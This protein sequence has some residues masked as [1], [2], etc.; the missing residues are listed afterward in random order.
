LSTPAGI[1]LALDEIHG[2]AHAEIKLGAV[3]VVTGLQTILDILGI[4]SEATRY[5]TGLAIDSPA[6]AFEKITIHAVLGQDMTLDIGQGASE[7]TELAL[8]IRGTIINSLE[9]LLK[10]MDKKKFEN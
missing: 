9:K 10:E 6:T 2:L 8:V 5:T 7:I 4:G 3:I 1:D